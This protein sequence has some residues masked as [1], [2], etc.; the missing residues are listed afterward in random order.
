[1]SPGS[2]AGRVLFQQSSALGSEGYTHL[3]TSHGQS[4]CSHGQITC[5]R[6]QSTCSRGQTSCRQACLKYT[7]K[8]QCCCNIDRLLSTTVKFQSSK[9]KVKGQRSTST[10]EMIQQ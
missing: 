4:T 7:G 1:M 10:D 2:A 9:V 5:S 3:R 8:L 6:G